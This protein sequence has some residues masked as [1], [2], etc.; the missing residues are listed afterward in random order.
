M[1]SLKNLGL[2]LLVIGAACSVIGAWAIRW[3]LGLWLLSIW[4]IVAGIAVLI[5]AGVKWVISDSATQLSADLKARRE[6]EAATREGRI[7]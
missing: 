2:A 1:P 7:Q 4:L 5:R 6:S 3:W